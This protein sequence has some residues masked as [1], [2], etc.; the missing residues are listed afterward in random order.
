MDW[1]ERINFMGTQSLVEQNL[2][3]EGVKSIKDYFAERKLKKSNEIAELKPNMPEPSSD[4]V[5]AVR[6]SSR[7]KAIGPEREL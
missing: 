1:K 7:K 4:V 5:P 6:P 2:I 3:T